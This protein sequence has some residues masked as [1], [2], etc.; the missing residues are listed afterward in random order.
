MPAAAAAETDAVQRQKP[1]ALL[2]TGRE[3]GMMPTSSAGAPR[4]PSWDHREPGPLSLLSGL[5][6]KSFTVLQGFHQTSSPL[7][8]RRYKSA[9]TEMKAL[10]ISRRR[11]CLAL[12]VH[13]ESCRFFEKPRRWF[14]ALREKLNA[15][16]APATEVPPSGTRLRFPTGAAAGT[17]LMPRPQVARTGGMADYRGKVLRS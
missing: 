9:T 4:V 11:K 17:P 1:R 10:L 2:R 8:G 5:R 13:R 15:Q 6:R 14:L 7:R 3:S 16:A 12:R